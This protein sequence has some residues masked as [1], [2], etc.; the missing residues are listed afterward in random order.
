MK[1]SE[2]VKLNEADLRDKLTELQNKYRDLKVAHAIT[3][4][5]NPAQLTILRKT[6]ARV[7]TEL[8]AKSHA[9]I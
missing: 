2:I 3:P 5:E 8:T 4:L 6:I 9:T 7:Q 1:Q